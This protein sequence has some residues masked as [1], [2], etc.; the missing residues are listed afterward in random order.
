[1]DR[2][3]TDKVLFHLVPAN[4]AAEE[5]LRHPDN[6]RFVSLS[7][8]KNK[9]GLEIGFHVPP[10]SRGHVIARLGRNTDLILRES[11]SAVHVAFEIHPETLVVMLSVRT[12]QA[13]SV[14]VATL[15]EEG[16]DND[17]ISGDCAIIYGE[18]YRIGIAS[19]VFNLTWRDLGDSDPA[20][21]LKGLTMKG[22]EDSMVRLKDV[23]SRDRS[24]LETS[25]P[26]SWYMTRLQSSKAP[27][28]REVDLARLLIGQG[29]FGKVYK[30]IDAATG[31]YFAVKVVD[32]ASQGGTVGIELA[33]AA[34]HKE[35]KIMERVS[36]VRVF[37]FVSLVLSYL[38]R[39]ANFKTLD[40]TAR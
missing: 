30:T 2:K 19:Y 20:A 31:N 34:L 1:M 35:M 27:L 15:E 14:T 7:S 22:Y 25:T 13:S 23:R 24:L 3:P 10:F 17:P 26:N 4:E 11:Y 18:R 29:A 32:L 12:K 28:V 16:V 37:L 8:S 9:P 40:L 33:R 6:R 36:H 38:L 5:A 21:A 39:Q